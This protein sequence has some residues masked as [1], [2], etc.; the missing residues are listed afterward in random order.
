[1]IRRAYTIHLAP[2]ALAEYRE[3]HDNIWPELVE[4]FRRLGFAQLTAFAAYPVVFYYAEITN[5]QAFDGLW[6]STVQA[7]WADEFKGLIAFDEDG[8]VSAPFMTEI[9]HLET[10]ANA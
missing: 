2:G 1:M 5:E 9:F 3:K 7:R 10:A 6:E 8:Q 4:E